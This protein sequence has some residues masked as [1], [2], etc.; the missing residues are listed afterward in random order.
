M[1]KVSPPKNEVFV[2][3]KGYFHTPVSVPNLVQYCFM[4]FFFSLSLFYLFIYLFLMHAL[5]LQNGKVGKK[6][7]VTRNNNG[8]DISLEL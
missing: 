8:R 6:E 1:L 2:I 3:V 7:N 5:H 4:H